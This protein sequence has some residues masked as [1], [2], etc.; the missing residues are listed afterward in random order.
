MIQDDTPAVDA[1]GSPLDE[2][3]GTPF[4]IGEFSAEYVDVTAIPC[5]RG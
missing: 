1:L 5:S 4:S 2:L 3:L